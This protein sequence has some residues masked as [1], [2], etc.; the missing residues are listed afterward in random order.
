MQYSGGIGSWATAMRVKAEHGTDNLVLLIADT[1]A[2]DPD[3]WRFVADS[4]ALLGVDPVVVADGR[5]PWQVFADQRFVGNSR[6][7]PCSVHLK[8]KPCRAWLDANA[9]PANTILYVGIDWSEQRRVLAIEKGWAPWIVRFPM[10]DEPHLNKQQM[11]DWACAEGLRPPRLYEQGFSH[12]NCHGVCVRAGQRQWRH[13]LQV[14]PDRY[15]AAEAEEEKL[16]AQLGTVAILKERRQGV[17]Y[18][19]PLRELRR[20]AALPSQP[21]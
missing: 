16:R 18:P 19:L 14:A 17:S 6:I 21:A 7:A 12:N 10:C 1:K 11:L 3:L 4:S 13:L 9:D 5:S 8:Q 20:R 2:E 15:L